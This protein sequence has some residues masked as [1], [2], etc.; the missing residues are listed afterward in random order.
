[1]RGV[2]KEHGEGGRLLLD[3]VL[4]LSSWCY[5]V[6]HRARFVSLIVKLEH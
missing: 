6:T 3:L 1:M 5:C 2:P 4:V